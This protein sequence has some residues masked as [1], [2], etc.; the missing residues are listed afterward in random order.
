MK[1]YAILKVHTTQHFSI[2]PSSIAK[3]TIQRDLASTFMVVINLNT[4][5]QRCVKRWLQPSSSCRM[6]LVDDAVRTRV[7][8]LPL[9]R[10]SKPST[11]RAMISRAI[12]QDHHHL[13]CFFR[14]YDE[15]KYSNSDGYGI[16]VH[17]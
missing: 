14:H 16:R 11:R 17:W 2:R 6:A 8:L 7:P 4:I 13:Q 9:T 3:I 10:I 5:L 15:Q 1:T 12:E